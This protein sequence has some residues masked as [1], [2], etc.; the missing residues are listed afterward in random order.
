MNINYKILEPENWNRL[1]EIYPEDRPL[2]NPLTASACIA[3]A[4]GKIV[5]CLFMQLAVHMEPLLRT[6]KSVDFSELAKPLTAMLPAGVQYFSQV[7]DAR[8]E[9]IASKLGMQ[10][11]GTE[12]FVGTGGAE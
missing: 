3:E 7:P 8:M 10:R 1:N 5:G 11:T 9:H 2:P 4:D 12:W 6:D